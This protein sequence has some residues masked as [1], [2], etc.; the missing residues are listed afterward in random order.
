M[1]RTSYHLFD[2]QL[3][4]GAFD[5]HAWNGAW[6]LGFKIEVRHVNGVMVDKTY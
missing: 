3:G 2:M 6:M 5:F 1:Q 4:Y